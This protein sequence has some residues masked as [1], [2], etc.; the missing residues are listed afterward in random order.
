MVWIDKNKLPLHGGGKA[1][2]SYLHARDLARAIHL[3][4]SSKPNGEIYNVGPQN[5]S[6][7]EVVEDVLM[8]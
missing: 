6:I 5:P 2:K 3:V 4:S 7:K 8:L 1:E